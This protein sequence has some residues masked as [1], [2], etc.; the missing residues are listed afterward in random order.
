MLLT[1]NNISCFEG[2]RYLH[3]ST[4]PLC[5]MFSSSDHKAGRNQRGIAEYSELNEQI[6]LETRMGQK[7]IDILEPLS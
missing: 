2:E 5:G 4:S 3:N 1:L 7:E 6:T